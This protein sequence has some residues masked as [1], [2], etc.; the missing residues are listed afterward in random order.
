MTPTDIEIIHKN[1]EPVGMNWYKYNDTFY[2]IEN[3]TISLQAPEVIFFKEYNS[4]VT[5]LLSV[6][7]CNLYLNGINITLQS[8][9]NTINVYRDGVYTYSRFS[10]NKYLLAKVLENR[11][12]D[13]E[14]VVFLITD[15]IYNIAPNVFISQMNDI[16]SVFMINDTSSFTKVITNSKNKLVLIDNKIVD[17][18][19]NEIYYTITGREFNGP[20]DMQYV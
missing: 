5:P 19:T 15:Y 10:E 6:P 8:P 12:G 18:V 16:S 14:E 1:G 9:A 4:Y 17:S 2:L 3:K 20:I 7:G 13:A 11:N